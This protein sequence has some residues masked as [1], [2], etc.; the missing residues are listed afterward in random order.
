MRVLKGV[1]GATEEG[2]AE[3]MVRVYED[4]LE[5]CWREWVGVSVRVE[6]RRCLGVDIS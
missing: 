4:E 2:G 1:E 5:G 3:V 6:L